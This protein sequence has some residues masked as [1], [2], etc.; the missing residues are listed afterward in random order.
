MKGNKELMANNR[1]TFPLFTLDDSNAT[2]LNELWNAFYRGVSLSD[3]TDDR[4][5]GLQVVRYTFANIKTTTLTHNLLGC[6]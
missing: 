2:A 3:I 6:A 1:N 5:P 4:S